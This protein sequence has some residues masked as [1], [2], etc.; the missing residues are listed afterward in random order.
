MLS[1]ADNLD[2]KLETMY[3]ALESKAPQNDSGWIG[4]NRLLDSNIRRTSEET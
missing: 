4:Y 2:A 3:E 1:S